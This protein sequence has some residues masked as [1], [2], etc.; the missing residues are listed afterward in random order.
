MTRGTSPEAG[1]HGGLRGGPPGWGN[2]PPMAAPV[3]KKLGTCLPQCLALSG[4]QRS[5]A[6]GTA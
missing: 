1:H 6:R 5:P 2:L 3:I 4:S